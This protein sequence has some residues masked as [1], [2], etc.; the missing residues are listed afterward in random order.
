MS[1]LKALTT[2]S[3]SCGA[4][5]AISV[6]HDS[7]VLSVSNVFLVCCK[8]SRKATA[9]SALPMAKSS[10]TSLA[11]AAAV[12]GRRPKDS[13]TMYT[14]DLWLVESNDG[15]CSARLFSV[16]A[17]QRLYVSPGVCTNVHHEVSKL[18]NEE[19]NC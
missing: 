10:P 7:D 16:L 8:P 17:T 9:T 19:Q 4:I 6:A 13:P 3:T 15:S 14:K 12:A 11:V 1:L 5:F 2:V 18:G